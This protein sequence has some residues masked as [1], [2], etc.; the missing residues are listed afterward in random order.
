MTDANDEETC[1]SCRFYKS[2][3]CRFNPPSIVQKVASPEWHSATGVD[4]MWP[5]VHASDWC[6]RYES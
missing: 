6:G 2:E 1:G 5:D 4:F 3:E